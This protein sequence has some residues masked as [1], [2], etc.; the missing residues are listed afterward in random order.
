MLTLKKVAVTGGLSCGKTSV[1]KL[2]REKGAYIVSADDIVHQLLSPNSKIGPQIVK[3]LGKEILS[4]NTFDRK[5]IANKVFN[6]P[7]TLKSLEKILHPAV[8]E[9]I[10]HQYAQVKNQKHFPLFVAEIPLLYEIESQH[11]FDTVITVNCDQ[12][13]P[14]KR[15]Q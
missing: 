8:L 7:A 2:F 6:H 4:G 3:L 9:E 5:K 1:C 12:S 14:K 10:E 13:H 11:L 15:F